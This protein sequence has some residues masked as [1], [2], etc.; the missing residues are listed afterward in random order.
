[1]EQEVFLTPRVVD[2]TAFGRY[3]ATLKE[4]IREAGGRGEQ[5]RGFQADATAMVTE[6]DRVGSELKRKL[7]VGAKLLGTIDERAAR[8]EK[9]L[10]EAEE[11]AKAESKIGALVERALAQLEERAR[12]IEARVKQ[13]ERTAGAAASNLS[14]VSTELEARLADIESRTAVLVDKAETAGQTLTGALEGVLSNVQ[15]EADQL[16]GLMAPLRTGVDR[17]FTLLGID[18]SDPMKEA[19]GLAALID[20]G[21]KL[22]ERVET[23]AGQLASLRQA[24]DEARGEF[25]RS[26]LRAADQMDRIEARREAISGPLGRTA[27]E[28]ERRVGPLMDRLDRAAAQAREVERAWERHER[29][30]AAAQD[31]AARTASEL[32]NKADQLDALVNGATRKLTERVEEAGRWLGQLIKRAEEVGALWPIEA[33]AQRAVETAPRRTSSLAG[34]YVEQRPLDAVPPAAS[35]RVPPVVINAEPLPGS[36]PHPGAPTPMMPGVSPGAGV[37]WAGAPARPASVF[38]PPVNQGPSA[39]P[40]Q[41]SHRPVLRVPSTPIDAQD[42]SG[43]SNVIARGPSV[44]DRPPWER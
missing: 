38:V 2:E 37:M 16:E 21:E 31:V 1:M 40:L 5:L 15:A 18:P 42:F 7:E 23:T 17:A 34:S 25:D 30:A 28:L 10:G 41:E 44:P 20:R 11:A 19:A 32:Q 12:A 24:A 22:T 35:P 8:A 4:L 26:I 14:M 13:A 6:A 43:A 36:L 29:T 39:A 33:A 9:L 27:E 3:S